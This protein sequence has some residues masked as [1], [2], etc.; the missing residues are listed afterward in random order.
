SHREP[1]WRG[2][3][4]RGVQGGRA[5]ARSS[6]RAQV[7]A[8]D[9]VVVAR[10]AEPVSRRS[11]NRPAG[12]APEC[13]SHLRRR[14]CR[15]VELSIAALVAGT[16]GSP[17]IAVMTATLALTVLIVLTRFGLL[18]VVGCFAMNYWISLLRGG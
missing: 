5:Q 10:R 6:G 16:S 13:L 2:R 11:Q 8:G 4:G 7:P 1:G 14:G 18:A 17:F 15:W 12:V 3:H 9:A